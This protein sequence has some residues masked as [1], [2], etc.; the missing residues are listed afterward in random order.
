MLKLVADSLVFHPADE[1]PTPDMGGKTVLLLNPCD[2]YHIGYVRDFD[3]YT[4]IFTW[5]MSELTPHDFYVAWALLPDNIDLS[6]KFEGQR[7]SRLY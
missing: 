7:E 4:G 1:K 6:N 3:G 5:L 2:G